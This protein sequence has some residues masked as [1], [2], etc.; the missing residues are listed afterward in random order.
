MDGAIRARITG[1][2]KIWGKVLTSRDNDN[3]T[4]LEYT[5]TKFG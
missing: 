3:I 4:A 5:I 2:G 1:L